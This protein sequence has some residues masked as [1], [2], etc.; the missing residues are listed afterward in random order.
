MAQNAQVLA[1]W[2]RMLVS[3]ASHG[4]SH[5]NHVRKQVCKACAHAGVHGMNQHDTYLERPDFQA[6]NNTALLHCLLTV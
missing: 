5:P 1:S 4:S 6:L 2:L 3:G